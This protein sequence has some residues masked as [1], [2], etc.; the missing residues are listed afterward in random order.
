MPSCHCWYVA[1]ILSTSVWSK[2]LVGVETSR[3]KFNDYVLVSCGFRVWRLFCERWQPSRM[4]SYNSYVPGGALRV[5][6]QSRVKFSP[7]CL[8]L[9]SLPRAHL[10]RARR[11]FCEPNSAPNS[12][13]WLRM[14]KLVHS[15][16]SPEHQLTDIILRLKRPAIPEFRCWRTE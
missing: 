8:T 2:G 6:Q 4:N 9:N 7:C 15:P 12:N 3:R 1:R 16:V 13:S 11:S 5:A 14:S 10:V